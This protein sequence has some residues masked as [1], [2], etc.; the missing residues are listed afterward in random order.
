MG[1]ETPGAEKVIEVRRCEPG[2]LSE[3]QEILQCAPEAAAWSEAALTETLERQPAHFLAAWQ[4]EKIAGFVLGR[5]MAEEGEILNLA[6]KTEYR[7]R[8]VARTL[9]QTLLDVFAAEG[10]GKAF[11]EVR[12]SNAAAI[13]LYK[14][15]GFRP[16]GRRPGYYHRPEEAALLL[17]AKIDVGSVQAVPTE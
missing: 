10:V 9:V 3:I 2:H 1:A 15:L 17:E 4:G 11:L 5:K 16:A 6:V 8:G 12:E 14:H 7:R 13:A